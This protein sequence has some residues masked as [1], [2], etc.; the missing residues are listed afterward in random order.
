MHIPM[1]HLF[2]VT[3]FKV[4][5]GMELYNPLLGICSYR[6]NKKGSVVS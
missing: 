4:Y 6:T 3:V 5:C 1:F 2:P